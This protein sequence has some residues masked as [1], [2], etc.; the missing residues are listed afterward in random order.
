V[1]A[2]DI[3]SKVRKLVLGSL[4][5]AMLVT[6][7]RFVSVQTPVLRISFAYV[8]LMLGGMLLGPAWNTLLAVLGD[9]LGMMLFPRGGTFFIGYTASAALTGLAYGLFLYRVRDRKKFFLRLAAGNFC[10]LLFV[11]VGL[12][13]LWIAITLERAFFALLPAR[14]VTAAIRL[15]VETGTMFALKIALEKPVEKYLVQD[16]SGG[17]AAENAAGDS[18]QRRFPEAPSGGTADSRSSAESL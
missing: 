3:M 6:V 10:V 17:A 18:P 14:V 11:S 12:T 2:L 8:P 15:P 7:Q 13:S 1:E 4:L 16:G 5:L 9:I